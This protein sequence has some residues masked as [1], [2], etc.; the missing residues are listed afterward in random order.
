MKILNEAIK[1]LPNPLKFLLLL[2]ELFQ[3]CGTIAL[4]RS[5]HRDQFEVLKV[6]GGSTQNVWSKFL[7]RGMQ[8]GNLNAMKAAVCY[9]CHGPRG[10]LEASLLLE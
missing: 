6:L 5:W 7:S 2:K 9:I 1:L 8:I 4:L 3:S 10:Q